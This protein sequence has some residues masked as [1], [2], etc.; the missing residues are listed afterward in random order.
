MKTVIQNVKCP[1]CDKIY[2][3]KS[4]LFS[5]LKKIHSWTEQ[6]I[7][8]EKSKYTDMWTEPEKSAHQNRTASNLKKYGCAN[9]FASEDSKNKIKKTHLDKYGVEHASQA[10][11]VKD[12]IKQTSLDRYGVECS[13][14]SESVKDKIKETN[15]ERYGCVCSLHNKKIEKKTKQTNLERYGTE[16]GLGS[17]MIQEKGEAT[18]MKKYGVKRAIKNKEILEKAKQSHIKKFGSWYSQTDAHQKAN[19]R[20]YEYVFPSGRKVSIMG[21]E[22]KAID[23]LLL[24][25]YKEE[26]LLIDDKEIHESIGKFTYILDGKEKRYFPDI[27]V[28]SEKRIIEVKSIYTLKNDLRKNLYKRDSVLNR[29]FKFEFLVYTDNGQKMLLNE[30]VEKIVNCSFKNK[31]EEVSIE[32]L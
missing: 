14:Q 15:L 30:E 21:Y 29:G 20:N 3:T 31:I 2:F 19:Y 11:E 18:C 26:D 10:K 24:L 4:N 23:Y 6:Q 25:N 7:K 16:W 12:K 9:V 5:H 28:I 17:R 32:N 27:Y 8:E 22:S 1:V 13:F